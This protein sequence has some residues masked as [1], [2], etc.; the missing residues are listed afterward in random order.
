MPNPTGRTVSKFV[1]FYGNGYDLSGD[2]RAVGPLKLSNIQVD[3]SAFPDD[4]KGYLPGQAT[5]DPGSLN[6]NFNN[7]TDRS[8]PVGNAG[9]GIM[10]T[11]IIPIGIQRIPDTGDPAFMGQF[12]QLAFDVAIDASGGITA[13]LN[14]AASSGRAST[15]NYANPWGLMLFA[16]TVIDP[17]YDVITTLAQFGPNAVSAGVDNGAASANGG[18]AIFQLFDFTGGTGPVLKI[19]HSVDNVDADYSDLLSSGVILAA[20]TA[21]LIP[22]ANFA[23]VKEWLRGMVIFN[24]ATSVTFA[25]AFVRD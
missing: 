12:E 3:N 4:L 8:L 23:T 9:N 10:Q 20:H 11:V 7:A 5:I 21:L 1:R 25:I 17:N 2:S 13:T 22:L 14:L 24:G 16:S 6:T 18:Y 15:F 19:Q